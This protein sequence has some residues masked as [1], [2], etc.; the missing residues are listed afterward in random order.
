MAAEANPAPKRGQSLDIETSTSPI[1]GLP[2]ELIKD[3]G[4]LT[5]PEYQRP[6]VWGLDRVLDLVV[7]LW[8][9]FRANEQY[10]IGTVVLLTKNTTEAGIV[11][12]QQRFTTMSIVAAALLRIIA[13]EQF[14]VPYNRDSWVQTLCKVLRTV[15]TRPKPRL[16]QRKNDAHALKNWGKLALETTRPALNEDKSKFAHICRAVQSKLN[17]L[18]EGSHYS[19]SSFP[20]AEYLLESVVCVNMIS[21]NENVALRVF[22]VVN[23]P[24]EALDASSMLKWKITSELR[25]FGDPDLAEDADLLEGQWVTD[26]VS[27]GDMKDETMLA[28]ARAWC[29]KMSLNPASIA[30]LVTSCL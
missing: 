12:G 7:D 13:A 29:M 22:G 5:I 30:G 9:S 24:G 18:F 26:E 21:R 17:D 23:T 19:Q 15:Q 11:D 16:L 20:F 6:Y 27:L 1:L 4:Q 10:F 14:F 8:K 28:A 3:Y 25:K 2:D